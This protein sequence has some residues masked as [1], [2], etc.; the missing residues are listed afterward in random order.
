MLRTLCTLTVFKETSQPSPFCVGSS[1]SCPAFRE[2]SHMQLL[3][4]ISQAMAF[5]QHSGGVSSLPGSSSA[6][7]RWQESCHLLDLGRMHLD[8]QADA[9]WFPRRCR[10]DCRVSHHILHVGLYKWLTN[11][12][13]HM[14]SFMPAFLTEGWP[15]YRAADLKIS[16][17][18]FLEVSVSGVWGEKEYLKWIPASLDHRAHLLS[19]ELLRGSST[20]LFSVIDIKPPL[21]IHQEVESIKNLSW[22]YVAYL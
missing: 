5:P 21:L 6:G 11:C 4:I 12:S 3:S 15:F 19:L 1:Q 14:L 17:L 20:F 13:F 9:S 7:S 8:A 2:E 16:I 18:C 10:H 22:E